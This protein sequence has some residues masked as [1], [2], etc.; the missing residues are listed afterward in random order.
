MLEEWIR[1]NTVSNGRIQQRYWAHLW[2]LWAILFHSGGYTPTFNH[3]DGDSHNYATR[4]HQRLPHIEYSFYKFKPTEVKYQYYNL[5]VCNRFIVLF[6]WHFWNG[7]NMFLHNI[8]KLIILS[9][10][11]DIYLYFRTAKYLLSSSF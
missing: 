7:F 9:V 6:G 4:F 8:K 5:N 2:Y 3:S 11:I 10:E 1:Q